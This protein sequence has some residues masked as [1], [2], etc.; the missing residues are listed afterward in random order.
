[1]D[2]GKTVYHAWYSFKQ[3]NIRRQNKYY[4]EKVS[5][6]KGYNNN[7]PGCIYWLSLDNKRLETT[8]ITKEKNHNCNT[9][10]LDDLVYLG[11]VYKCAGVCRW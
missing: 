1:M 4:Q 10:N 3:E 9:K 6:N 11:L 2:K 8:M 5:F 7:C